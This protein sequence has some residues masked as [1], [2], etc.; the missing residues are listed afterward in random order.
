MGNRAAPAAAKIS[1][2]S[3]GTSPASNRALG[4][5]CSDNAISAWAQT[6]SASGSK[7]IVTWYG[8]AREPCTTARTTPGSTSSEMTWPLRA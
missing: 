4:K 1:S 5:A 8:R 7:P 3:G 6:G 2:S